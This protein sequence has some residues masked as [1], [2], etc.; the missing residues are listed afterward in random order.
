[1]KEMSNDVHSPR[2]SP[3]YDGYLKHFDF[4]AL[5]VNRARWAARHAAV[6]RL[7]EDSEDLPFPPEIRRYMRQQA[8]VVLTGLDGGSLYGDEEDEEADGE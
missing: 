7:V 4:I 3:Y 2:R 5:L 8:I 6:D 1:M